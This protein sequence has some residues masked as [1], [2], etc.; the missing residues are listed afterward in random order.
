MK[1]LYINGG[2]VTRDWFVAPPFSPN[3]VKPDV[4]YVWWAWHP[5]YPRWTKSCWEGATEDEAHAAL[6]KPFA[7]SMD[8]YHLKLVREG[9]GDFTEVFDVPCKRM[10]MWKDQV[11]HQIK[12]LYE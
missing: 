1:E 7:S 4:K 12:E 2:L 3:L 8:Y 6:S 9:D 5:L 11:S 10:E